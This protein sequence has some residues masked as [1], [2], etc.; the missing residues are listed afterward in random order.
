VAGQVLKI[1]IKRAVLGNVSNGFVST[2]RKDQYRGRKGEGSLRCPVSVIMSQEISGRTGLYRGR[3]GKQEQ[4]VAKVSCIS[5]CVPGDIL[6][7]V[8]VGYDVPNPSWSTLVGSRSTF[9][10]GVQMVSPTG[11]LHSHSVQVDL[12][13]K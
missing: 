13:L 12:K 8:P 2:K 9:D 3:Q 1:S 11:T 4:E 7:M 6:V 5:H 10:L